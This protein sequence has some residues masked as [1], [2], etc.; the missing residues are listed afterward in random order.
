MIYVIRRWAVIL[1]FHPIKGQEMEDRHDS[2]DK[3]KVFWR[4]VEFNRYGILFGA[5]LIQSCVASVA[6]AF[7]CSNLTI[8]D[9][10]GP[11]ILLSATTMGANAANIALA[12]MKWVIG[13]FSLVVVVSIGVFVYTFI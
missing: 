12:P 2:I 13:L 9:Q 11:L 6:V 5:I 1:E 10:T 3:K 4:K 8:E 7:V